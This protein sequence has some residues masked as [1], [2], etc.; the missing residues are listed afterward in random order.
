MRDKIPT[1]LLPV[2]HLLAGWSTGA[3]ETLRTTERDQQTAATE[4]GVV[5]LGRSFPK[6][7][8]HKPGALGTGEFIAVC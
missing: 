6:P 2:T 5:W 7:H 3:A 4:R 8:P 1:S